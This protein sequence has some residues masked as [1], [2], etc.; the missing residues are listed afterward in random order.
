MLL[1]L[2]IRVLAISD[3]ATTCPRGLA[4]SFYF[5]GPEARKAA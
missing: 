4:R 5:A 2:R 1:S 3:S